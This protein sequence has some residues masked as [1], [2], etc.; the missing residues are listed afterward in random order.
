MCERVVLKLI[1]FLGILAI[2]NN[3]FACSCVPSEIADEFK[4]TDSVF[5]GSVQKVVHRE[6]ITSIFVGPG[7][8]E[9]TF[10]VIRAIKGV[11]VGE[12][13]VVRTSDQGSACGIANWLKQKPGDTWI[14]WANKGPAMLTANHCSRTKPN[15]DAAQD[16]SFFDSLR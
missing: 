16:L 5:V 6:N 9:L 2:C 14:V 4:D 1:L 15:A 3:G 11:S 12:L 8:I 7:T 10:K 13:V